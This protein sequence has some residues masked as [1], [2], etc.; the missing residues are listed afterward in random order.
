MT[1]LRHILSRFARDERATLSVEAVII[2]PILFWAYGSMVIFWDAFKTQNINLK[3]AY[4]ISDMVSRLDGPDVD[5]AYVNGL[6]Q[7]FEFLNDG[8]HPARLRVSVVVMEFGSDGVTPEMRLRWSDVAGRN[9]VPPHSDMLQE[10]FQPHTNMIGLEPHV[11]IMAVADEVVIVETQLDYSPPF[12]F[13]M[14]NL[15]PTIYGSIIATRPRFNQAICYEG[16]Y[17]TFCPEP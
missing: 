17:D 6:H 4:T 3:A 11:P 2:I 10:T 16:V 12:D 14:F 15:E 5:E 1:R 7:M 8:E 9:P 13:P